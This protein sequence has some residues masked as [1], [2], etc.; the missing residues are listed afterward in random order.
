MWSDELDQVAL[1]QLAEAYIVRKKWEAELQ[2]GLMVRA[3]SQAMGGEELGSGGVGEQGHGR[4]SADEML[5]MMG[6]ADGG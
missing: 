4:V 3:L 2:A 5:R 6:M 1:R